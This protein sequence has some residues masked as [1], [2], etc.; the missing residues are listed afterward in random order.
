HYGRRYCFLRH[1]RRLQYCR[2]RRAD[3]LRRSPRHPRNHWQGPSQ[4]LSKRRIR[5]GSRLPGFHRR[6]K[7]LEEQAHGVVENACP[8][9]QWAASTWK[10]H[11]LPISLPTLNSIDKALHTINLRIRIKSVPKLGDVLFLAEGFEHFDGFF[12]DVVAGAVE[13]AGIEV[14]LQD[15]V[16]HELAGFADVHVPVETDCFTIHIV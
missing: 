5:P 2:A 15:F 7:E 12:S 6:Q 9:E 3:R 13:G 16:G 4:R 8:V 14:A 10:L 1:A 11:R